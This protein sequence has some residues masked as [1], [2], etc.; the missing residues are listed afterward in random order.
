MIGTRP[1]GVYLPAAARVLFLRLRGPRGHDAI[2]PRV[3]DE[4]TKVFV[5][6]G[7]ENVNNVALVSLRAE[8]WQQLCEI[9]V[10]HAIDRFGR[11]IPCRRTNLELWGAIFGRFRRGQRNLVR[12]D[13]KNDRQRQL[14]VPRSAPL[15]VVKIASWP[16]HSV[17]GKPLFSQGIKPLPERAPHALRMGRAR[18]GR[19]LAEQGLSRHN[20]GLRL[21]VKILGFL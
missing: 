12:I 18:Y 3:G 21:A 17:R 13:S 4:L 5:R 9:R 10:A 11:E 2:L 16:I 14:I 7:N 1:L 19:F 6:V 8:L 20:S 15:R